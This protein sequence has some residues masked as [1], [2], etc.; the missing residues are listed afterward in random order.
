MAKR[1]LWPT[2]KPNKCVDMRIADAASSYM[3]VERKS[4]KFTQFYSGSAGNLYLLDAHGERLLIECGVSWGKIREALEFDLSGIVGCLLTHEHQDH[5]KAVR[6][7]MKNG[8]KVFSSFGT[9]DSLSILSDRMSWELVDKEHFDIGGFRIHPYNA[10]HD[11]IEPYL[12]TIHH[13]VEWM[14]FATDTSFIK[15]EFRTPFDIIAIEC[16][17]D[18]D[19]L[20]AMVDAGKIH[21]TVA[22]RLLTSHLEKSNTMD[23][24][25]RCCDLS[26]CTEIHL[27]HCSGDNLDR[28]KVRQEFEDKYFIDVK[29]VQNERLQCND[30]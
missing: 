2:S 16:S 4:M 14:L 1:R 9:I 27:L 3:V 23:Y 21:E 29:V 11:C 30:R 13:G 8:I 22:K 10:H 20:R 5:C 24:L 15:Q 18:K 17:Y 28:E 26:K 12:Y 19:T 25:T 7:V 6:D